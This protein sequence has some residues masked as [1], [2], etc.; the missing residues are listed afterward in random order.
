M[1]KRSSPGPRFAGDHVGWLEALDQWM[2]R[3]R[4]A[5]SVAVAGTI[6]VDVYGAQVGT[7]AHGAT[8][9]GRTVFSTGPLVAGTTNGCVEARASIASHSTA[10]H[11]TVHDGSTTKS[12]ESTAE[13]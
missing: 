6:R 11:G 5:S 10:K 9:I 12:A 2:Q 13:V 4:A 1:Q 3:R 8:N 7:R